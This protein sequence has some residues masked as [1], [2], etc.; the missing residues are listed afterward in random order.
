MLTFPDL[1]ADRRAPG[2]SPKIVVMLLV[3]EDPCELDTYQLVG[4][5]ES[6]SHTELKANYSAGIC[7]F[8]FLWFRPTNCEIVIFIDLPVR[9]DCSAGRTQTLFCVESRTYS[10]DF[11]AVS[12]STEFHCRRVTRTGIHSGI[13][14]YV[15]QLL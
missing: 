11:P 15:L 1:V 12:I 14:S 9:Q 2:S 6:S 13:S 4:C 8:H 7:S 10:D 5:V 3:L